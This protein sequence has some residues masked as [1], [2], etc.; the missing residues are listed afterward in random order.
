LAAHA[1]KCWTPQ[2]LKSYPD[3][4]GRLKILHDYF[5]F[6]FYGEMSQMF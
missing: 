2:E 1:E 3:F 5:K 6:Q 4:T